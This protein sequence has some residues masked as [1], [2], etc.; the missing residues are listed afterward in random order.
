MR[1]HVRRYSWTCSCPVELVLCPKLASIHFPSP[2]LDLSPLLLLCVSLALID[3]SPINSVS[4]DYLVGLA[5]LFTS[6]T[7]AISINC[8]HFFPCLH[9]TWERATCRTFLSNNAD[10]HRHALLQRREVRER[11]GQ[12]RALNVVPNLKE[13]KNPFGCHKEYIY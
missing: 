9:H 5:I 12:M 10:Y 4:L 2:A 6:L 13:P 7:T 3:V 8:A 1:H 11:W